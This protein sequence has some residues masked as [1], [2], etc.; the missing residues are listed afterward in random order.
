[1]QEM[2]SIV[3]KE[4]I[5]G[6]WTEMPSNPL[7]SVPDLKRL[8]KCAHNNGTVLVVD[9]TVGSYNVN[10]MKHGCA[11]LVVTS[12]SKMFSGTCN[13]M[14]GSV[15]LN[16]ESPLAKEL[17][18]LFDPDGD[19]FLVEADVDILL[20]SSNNLAERLAKANATT[21]EIVRR[22]LN[23]PAVKEV[24]YPMLGDAKNRFDP[25]LNPLEEKDKPRYG[26]VLSILLHG[27]LDPAMAFYDALKSAKGASLGTN[28]TLSCPYPLLAHYDELDFA[29]SCGVD[30]NLIRISIGQE[31][32][33]VIWADFKQALDIASA[34][35]TSE[36][37]ASK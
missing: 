30:R 36:T 23:H 31:D 35:R 1:M 10:A 34:L 2:E 11:D 5:L 14:A 18:S 6:I 25:F 7:L 3:A 20:E 15:V 33:E 29:E 4:K 24:Y 28:F 27:G 9:D 37:T 21:V 22:L 26:P 17:E 12:L 19:S 32:C 8:A 16:P 13:V